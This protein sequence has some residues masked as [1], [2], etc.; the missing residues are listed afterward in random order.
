MRL[1]TRIRCRCLSIYIYIYCLLP[2][3]QRE[4]K[5]VS[6]ASKLVI[7]ATKT[8]STSATTL[9][10]CSTTWR[11]VISSSMAHLSDTASITNHVSTNAEFVVEDTS[12]EHI[13]VY[14]LFLLV[15]FQTPGRK[16]YQRV[17]DYMK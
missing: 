6:Y 11:D 13:F 14:K 8:T 2:F 3:V 9:D 5:C 16:H 4:S 12:C 15:M 7:K 17:F 10:R 1:S